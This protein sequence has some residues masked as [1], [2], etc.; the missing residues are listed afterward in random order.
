[1]RVADVGTGGP[2]GYMTKRV[3]ILWRDWKFTITESANPACLYGLS[4]SSG[5]QIEVHFSF[6]QDGYAT[7]VRTIG[8]S[9]SNG[10]GVCPPVINGC[11]ATQTNP[12]PIRVNSFTAG[13]SERTDKVTFSSD[14]VHMGSTGITFHCEIPTPPV[15]PTPGVPDASENYPV[16]PYAGSLQEAFDEIGKW[17]IEVRPLKGSCP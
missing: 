14:W 3:R 4:F 17:T 12:D 8:A 10:V 13:Y 7:N 1:V 5:S 6:D 11:T 15:E 9:S 16:D 2:I